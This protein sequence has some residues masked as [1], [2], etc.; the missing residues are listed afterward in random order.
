M[1]FVPTD[2]DIFQLA[3]GLDQVTPTNSLKPGVARNALNW[4][5]LVN[6]GYGRIPGYEVTDGRVPSPSD[7]TFSSFTLTSVAAITIGGAVANG[8]GA[9]GTVI[10]IDGLRVFYTQQVGSF[11][12]GNTI[13]AGPTITAIGGS[14]TA[15]KRLDYT[16]AASNVYRA[17]I[18]AIPGAGI[19]RGVAYY[20]S[21]L[22]GWRNNAGATLLEM[23]KATSGGWVKII[24]GY[25]IAFSGGTVA[26]TEPLNGLTI[27]KGGV[28][29]ILRKLVLESGTWA[30]GTAA[31][32][33]ITDAPTGGAFTAGAITGGTSG[34]VANL[35]AGLT[36]GLVQAVIAFSPGGRVQADQ[37]SFGGNQAKNLYGCDN[38]NRGWEFDGTT[39]VPIRTGMTTDAPEN[40]VVHKN[41]LVFSFGSSVQFCALG[42]PYQWSP[43]LGAGEI[44]LNSTVTAFVTPPGNQTSGALTIYS[45]DRTY[46][47]YG[48]V[49]GSGGDAN[50]VEFNTGIGAEKYTAQSM[51]QPYALASRGVVGLSASQ[52]YG[53]FSADTLTLTLK[54]FIQSHRGTAVASGLNREKS[55]YR[56]FYSNGDALYLTIVNGK[57]KGAM[58]ITFPDPAYC[59]AEA[60]VTSAEA[61]YFGTDDG[62]VMQMD[63]GANFNGEPIPHMLHTNY[64]NVKNQR[65]LKRYRKAALE[66]NGSTQVQFNAGYS[67]GYGDATVKDQPSYAS[68]L[69]SF[70]GTEQWDSFVWDSFVWDGIGLGPTEV[71]LGGSAENIS[72]RFQG[73]SNLYPAFSI[74]TITIHYTPRRGLR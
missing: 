20:N 5:I 3:G 74:N 46:L 39:M 8:L 28:T 45:A 2:F 23:Y 22:Y 21:V 25:E 11:A 71:E 67:L 40:V 16:L 30:G 7:A 62:F 73:S 63:V 13:N 64:N 48:T 37:K 56:V 14:V 66:V 1:K 72:M 41:Y 9:T 32:R 47:L 24:F 52:N 38:V 33:F 12:V 60:G 36:G 54:P 10:A 27:T 44:A 69:T 55:Q 35:I 34:A 61:S 6:G 58:P 4:E 57:Y 19:I 49:F 65:L 17:L 26:P 18:G 70:S 51:E 42:F 68:A 15:A 29:G 50:L 31:G 53:N 43:L 59:W